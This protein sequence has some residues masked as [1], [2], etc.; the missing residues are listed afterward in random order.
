MTALAIERRRG[1]FAGLISAYNQAAEAWAKQRE[2]RR[3]RRRIFLELSS[4][5]DR[6]L[7]DLRIDRA[8]IP[9][10]VEGTYRR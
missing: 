3:E 1:P 6:D 7:Q 2:Q 5:S 8:D 4:C 10:I 9:A